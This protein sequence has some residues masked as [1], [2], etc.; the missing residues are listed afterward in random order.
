MVRGA[1]GRRCGVLHLHLRS[2]GEAGTSNG[3]RF[4]LLKRQDLLLFFF[5]SADLV[6]WSF[7]RLKYVGGQDVLAL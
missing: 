1:A 3:R 6:I 7:Y 4:L 2:D 5:P